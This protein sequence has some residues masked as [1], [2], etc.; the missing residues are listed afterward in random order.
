MLVRP[1][2][3]FP[4]ARRV[5]EGG[6]AELGEVFSFLSGLYF[7]GKLAYAETFAK[8]PK[9]VA[10]TLVITSSHGLLPAKTIV[11]ARDLRAFAEVPVDPTEERYCAPL[12]Q[13]A[14]ALDTACGAGAE[15][16]LLGSIATEKY[17]GCLLPIFGERLLF[18][19]DFAGRGDM[20][21]GGL[22]LRA[23]ASGE[24]LRYVP[25]SGALRR[26]PRPPKLGK[27]CGKIT[28]RAD[29]A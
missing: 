11:D 5:Q 2:A 7:R 4:L 16:V 26:G 14:K 28:A 10:R 21:R 29:S 20:S 9:G 12:R 17:C 18:P 23:V 1:E 3:E 19:G 13:S 27:L 22:M 8:P 25:V 15:I 24:E 6:G